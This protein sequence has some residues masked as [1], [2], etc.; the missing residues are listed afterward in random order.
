MKL[1][2][3]SGTRKRETELQM[4]HK[5]QVQVRSS[6]IQVNNVLNYQNYEHFREIAG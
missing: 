5:T 3:T 1:Q 2:P 6:P 4:E